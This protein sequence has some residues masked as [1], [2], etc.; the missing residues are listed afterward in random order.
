MRQG[1]WSG[2][3]TTRSG[4]GDRPKAPGWTGGGPQAWF[5][6][7]MP[8]ASRA[9]PLARWVSIAA[10]PLVVALLLVAVVLGR[11]GW[12]EAARGVALVGAVFVLPVALLI[13]RQV[14]RGAWET[15]D[16]SRPRERPA[17]FAVGA[18]ALLA[19]W[20]L[21]PPGSPLRRGAAGVLAMVAVCAAVTPWVKVSLHVA[22]TALAAAVL[23]AR[24]VGEGGGV[25]LVLPV[26]AWSRVAM[27]R[28][29]IVEVALGAAI[30]LA[31]G[32]GVGRWG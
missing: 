15:V 9:A 13:A 16:A 19:M 20:W 12:G 21:E 28:H 31:A 4:A 17:L 23:L 32:W 1:N 3:R 6:R 5:A 2:R 29:R 30:G 11:R 24:G 25:A 14:R 26:L 18:L 10:H 7:M 8:P 22:T 27:G